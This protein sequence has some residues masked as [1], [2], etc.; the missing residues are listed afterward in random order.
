MDTEERDEFGQVK[1]VCIGCGKIP[2]DLPEY[3][4]VAA[5]SPNKMSANWK[6]IHVVWRDGTVRSEPHP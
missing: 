3:V 6:P 2:A 1:P 5:L 4:Q